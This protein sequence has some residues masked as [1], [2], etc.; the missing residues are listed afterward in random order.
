VTD[1]H[2]VHLVHLV[3]PAGYDDP[4]RPSGGNVYDAQLCAGLAEV[5]WTVVTHEVPGA[6]PEPDPAISIDVEHQLALIPDGQVAIVDG[7]LGTVAAAPLIRHASRLRLVALVHMPGPPGGPPGDVLRAARLV[8]STSDW[9]ARTLLEAH[10]LLVDR[11]LVALPGAPTAE[12]VTGTATGGSLLCVAAVTQSKGHDVLFAALAGLQDREWTCV[13]VGALDREPAFVDRQ[14]NALADDG[15]ADR[16]R[17]VGPLA[18][19]DLEHAYAEADLL[20]LPTRLESYGLVV[21]EAL[22]RGLPVIATSVGGVAEALG[23]EADGRRPGI[24]VEAGDARALREAVAQWLDGAELRADLRA[25]AQSR[26][27]VL[28]GWDLTVSLVAAAVNHLGVG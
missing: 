28:R 9:T 18:G 7:L 4:H 15:I 23:H 13:C 5:G 21:V 11:M 19:A 20:I 25:A 26:R 22:A 3:L 27:G 24:L 6:W 12:L 16:V 10:D 14:R 1:G 8:I 17:F 2:L